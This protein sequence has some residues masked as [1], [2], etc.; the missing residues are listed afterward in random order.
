M[1][2]MKTEM[3]KAS[4]TTEPKKMK[5]VKKA[6]KAKNQSKV[7][8]ALKRFAVLLLM[9]W[10][11]SI[12]IFFALRV[13]PG[14]IAA[15]MAGTNST[16]EK[17]EQ[18]RAELGLN[19]PL[20]VQ[21]GQWLGSIFT[22]H[23]GTSLLTGQ[24][25]STRLLTRAAVTFPLIVVSMVLTLVI[26]LPTAVYSLTSRHAWVRGGLRVISQILGAVPALWAALALIIVFG[27]GNGMLNVLPTQGFPS[28]PLSSPANV[29]SAAA[30]L[31]IPALSVSIIT[32]AHLMRYTRSAI[33]DVE[34]SDYITW[35]MASG[36]TYAQA[37]RTTGLRLAA[38]QIA[39]VAGVTFASMIT[40]VLT[41]E[42]L[43]NLP[44]LATMLMTDLSERDLASVQTELLLL[45]AFFLIVGFVIDTIVRMLDP[46]LK[47][48]AHSTNTRATQAIEVDTKRRDQ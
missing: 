19:Q 40:G 25:M 18:L 47:T 35:S 4:T 39:S 44:G 31:I 12:V 21:Y 36:M 34:K 30:S 23:L 28:N 5:K 45:S 6:K 42:T 13:L 27:K 7:A 1:T 9:L 41:V 16:P 3:T 8:I 11:V 38:P 14:D 17:Y 43:F 24:A 46:R 22:G 2:E 37:V 33:V 32:G 15:I 48:S 26:A 29:V 20:I 10:I